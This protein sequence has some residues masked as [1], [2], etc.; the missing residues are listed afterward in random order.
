MDPWFSELGD[1]ERRLLLDAARERDLLAGTYLFRRGD[2]IAETGCGLCVLTKGRLKVA[3]G[4]RRGNEFIFGFC[5]PGVWFGEESAIRRRTHRY[6]AFAI[7]PVSV[8]VIPQPRFRALLD[9][10]PRL[11]AAVAALLAKRVESLF[12]MVECRV[13]LTTRERVARHLFGMVRN[14]FKPRLSRSG[15]VPV[16]QDQLA[17]MIG[18]SRPTLSKELRFLADAKIIEI[19]YSRIHVLDVVR[20]GE[21]GSIGNLDDDPRETPRRT[22]S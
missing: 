22:G 4:D 12:T 20:L 15:I 6:D 1:E 10:S 13:L 16:S 17:M 19:R 9:E 7:E 5:S 11:T 18:V 21:I 3:T 2:A 8:L 14:G